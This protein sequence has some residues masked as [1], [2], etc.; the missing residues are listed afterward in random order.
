M[1]QTT[2]EVTGMSCTGCE[3]NVV[4]ALEG[5]DGVSEATADHESD[6]VR[7]EHNPALADAASIG[8][9]VEQ[10]GYTVSA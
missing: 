4:E 3:Q 8:G 1:E 6:E 2:L 9:A 7:V 5:L 10:A